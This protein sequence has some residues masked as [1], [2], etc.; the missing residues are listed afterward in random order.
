MIHYSFEKQKIKVLPGIYRNHS[1]LLELD[2]NEDNDTFVIL[3]TER[4][5]DKRSTISVKRFDAQGELIQNIQLAPLPNS[6]IL[7]GQTTNLPGKEQFIVGTY[8]HKRSNYSRGIFIA[9]LDPNSQAPPTLKYFNYGDLKNFFSYMKAKRAARVKQRVERRKIKGK[10][11]RFNYRLLVHDIVQD[12]E[13]NFLMIGEA[14]YP[15]Y[16]N[17]SSFS[18]YP[19]YGNLAFEGYK[20][21]HA[22]IIAFSPEGKLVYDNSFEI[23]DVQTFQLDQLVSLNVQDGKVILLYTYEDVIRSKIIQGNEVLEGKAF[24][25][26]ELAFEN[27]IVGN[28]NSEVGGL[29]KWYGDYFFAYGVQKIKNLAV[30]GQNISREVF[31]INKIFYSFDS[32][33]AE[34]SAEV[35]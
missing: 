30:T 22:V 19:G 34:T 33:S 3:M 14:Y 32:V 10:K 20:Y 6:S 35:R 18:Y 1:E 23:N 26:I 31:Y 11:L 5:R 13:G 21:T 15:K 7:Y 12:D 28:N 17:Y 25:E 27:D 2:I 4:T 9:Q 8:S 16:G 29:K 24:N